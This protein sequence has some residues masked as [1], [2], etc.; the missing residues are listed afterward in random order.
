MVMFKSQVVGSRYKSIAHSGI[1]QDAGNVL[2]VILHP[3]NR[4]N[5]GRLLGLGMNNQ[6][7]AKHGEVKEC[8]QS[9]QLLNAA[10]SHQLMSIPMFQRMLDKNIVKTDP[11]R[12]H[13][14]KVVFANKCV[15]V[16]FYIYYEIG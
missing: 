13:P 15:A 7:M 11:L 9:A 16:K 3:L 2:D 12:T 6:M 5:I 1:I 8:A 14:F 4:Q 10:G